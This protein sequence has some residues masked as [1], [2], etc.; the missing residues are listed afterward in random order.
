MGLEV[1]DQNR[2]SEG[3]KK[4]TACPEGASPSSLLF[5]QRKGMSFGRNP[6]EILPRQKRKGEKGRT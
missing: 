6:K 5:K 4:L 2:I 1:R 3:E